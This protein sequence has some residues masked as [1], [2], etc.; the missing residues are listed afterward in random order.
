M[1]GKLSIIKTK[2]ELLSQS[3]VRCEFQ[4]RKPGDPAAK[5]LLDLVIFCGPNFFAS[6]Q[7][8]AKLYMG[9]GPR[10]LAYIL[11][12]FLN[13]NLKSLKHAY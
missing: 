9:D 12:N 1:N 13:G 5:K 10:Q 2:K 6:L 4:S 8:I 3:T 11:S 7:I